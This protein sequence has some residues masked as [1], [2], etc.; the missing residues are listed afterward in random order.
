LSSTLQKDRT[1]T[2]FLSI[3]PIEH[4]ISENLISFKSKMA[5]ERAFTFQDFNDLASEQQYEGLFRL[6]ESVVKEHPDFKIPEAGLN[7]LALQLVFNP[8]TSLKGINLL[9][10]GTQLFPQSANLF[11]SLGEGYYYMGEQE[12]AIACFE[13]S[14]ELYPDNQNA[15]NR[16]G[17]LKK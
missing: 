7:Q 8:K 17:E 5:E 11:D 4:G 10:L 1:A 15:I 9:L 12:Q 14:V 13:K 16:L 2:E 3:N 6:Y